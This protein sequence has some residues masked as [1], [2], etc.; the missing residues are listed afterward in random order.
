[1][2]ILR[3]TTVIL[4]TDS[5]DYTPFAIE[6]GSVIHREIGGDHY[7]RL[8]FTLAEPVHLQVGDHI[9]A[10]GGDWY[11]VED[12]YPTYSKTTGGY[13]YDVQFESYEC[14]WK[15]FLLKYIP[16]NS[17][18]ETSF[19]L[20]GAIGTHVNVVLTNLK[21]HGFQFGGNDFI[22]DVST[23]NVKSTTDSDGN[24][25]TEAVYALDEAECIT[26]SS[27]SIYDALNAIAD[28]FECEWWVEEECI[29]FGFCEKTTATTLGVEYAEGTMTLQATGGSVD[30]ELGTNLGDVKRSESTGDYCT[31]LFAF[32]SDR[33]LTDYYRKELISGYT[34]ASKG[35]WYSTAI[36]EFTLPAV[37][38]G[39]AEVTTDQLA[40]G[41]LYVIKSGTA[42]DGVYKSYTATLSG[43]AI[44][45]VT[46]NSDGGYTVVLTV[47]AWELPD[48]ASMALGFMCECTIGSQTYTDYILA[49]EVVSED[50]A[51]SVSS[52]GVNAFTL[53]GIV[54]PESAFKSD[55]A[56]N[57]ETFY[58]LADGVYALTSGEEIEDADEYEITN[59]RISQVDTAYLTDSDVDITISGVASTR[60][61]LPDADTGDET[62][63]CKDG[64]IQLTGLA[65]EQHVEGTATFDDIYPRT[66]CT[67]S[68]LYTATASADDDGDGEDEEYDYY[69]VTSEDDF[70]Q[71]FDEDWIIEGETLHI[72]FTSGSLNGMDFECGFD[73]LSNGQYF[74]VVS[75]TDYGT[76]LPN[77]TLHP[78]VGDTFVIYGWDADALEDTT[79][80]A[81]AEEE[82]FEEALDYFRDCLVD[83][84]T[85]ECTFLP[86]IAYNGGDLL[87]YDIG[88]KVRLVHA[89]YFAEGY[90][91][92]RIMGYEIPLDI[93]YDNPTYIIGEKAE[94]SRLDALE[95][96]IEGTAVSG[97]TYLSSSSGSSVSISNGDKTSTTGNVYSAKYTDEHFLRKDGDTA[98]GLTTFAAGLKVGDGTYGIDADGN[99]TLKSVDADEVD[100]DTVKAG[101]LDVTGK[102]TLEGDASVGGDLSVTG[103]TTLKSGLSVAGTSD[104]TTLNVSKDASVSGDLS[105]S[106]DTDLQAV[107]SESITNEGTITTKNL[108]VT[109]TAHFFELV[110]DKVK[111]AGGA[112]MLTPADGF[113]VVGIT[114]TDGGWKLYFLAEDGDGNA[115]TNMWVAGDQALCMNFNEAAA[116][117]TS[118]VSNT[119]WWRLV[120]DVSEEAE[121][122]ELTIGEETEEVELTIGEETATY[123]CHWIE[124]SSTD[125][126]GDSTPSVGDEVV[127]CGNRSEEERQTA[128][129]ISAYTSLDDGLTA[130][131]YAHYIGIDDFSLSSHRQTYMDKTG[132]H[133]VGDFSVSS[134]T[135][136]EEYIT[137]TVGDYTPYVDSETGTLWVYKDGEWVD[138]GVPDAEHLTR[139]IKIEQALGGFMYVDETETIT[140]SVWD[141]IGLNEYTDDYTFTI[142][143]DSGDDSSDAVWNTAFA[144]K[145]DGGTTFELTFSDLNF[146]DGSRTTKF[147]VTAVENSSGEELEEEVIEY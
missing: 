89:G 145:Y 42:E 93:P 20:T 116:G 88:Q 81:D 130:P 136:L 32:G 71:N 73:A 138:T 56:I 29:Y 146:T 63:E 107:T 68:E 124:V 79:L 11:L 58:W 141:Y 108:T 57:G 65:E 27:S 112:V 50:G 100:G 113:T 97:A 114:E 9:E 123:K 69:Y 40:A 26:Y 75:N 134:G 102:S 99:A 37:E 19:V 17:A 43:Y 13:T 98:T 10:A 60:L 6:E 72:V 74:H 111:S 35:T 121:E 14:L 82:L 22:A 76:R 147:W 103:D 104:L 85:Y 5:A 126:D 144:A 109:G 96:S 77:E 18:K 125:Y 106:G 21:Y 115:I 62:I 38:D 55:S 28:A 46:R 142:E 90:R 8:K 30:F 119:Y 64:Y 2:E 140:L 127:M 83:P 91:D 24:E 23:Y 12:A 78:E 41:T 48:F 33:N 105:V 70:T 122:V 133:F 92:S 51:V 94:Y 54:L 47:A 25:T 117:S 4:S 137:E 1:M 53:D 118:E 36:V 66:Q 45:S 120:T 129:Y 143:R 110:I 34:V 59:I 131:L 3:D 135:T 49:A 84:S 139:V 16:D 86:D 44:E 7:L 15:N 61:R 132:A 31:R 128:I 95:K 52:A 80:I 39:T 101:T 67:V 87:L